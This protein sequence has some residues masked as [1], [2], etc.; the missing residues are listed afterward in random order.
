MSKNRF[1]FLH[2][3]LNFSTV[4]ETRDA[5]PSDRYAAFR[6]FW[7]IFNSNLS[8]PLTP[9]E[10]LSIDETLY[11]MRHQI[12]F[13]QF[14][15]K[16]LHKYGMLFKSLNDACFPYTYKAVPYAGKPTAGTGPYY[17]ESTIDYVK[18]LVKETE[19]D[20]Y[21]KGNFLFLFFLIICFL[22]DVISN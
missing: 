22:A 12:A 4:D 10:Y 5:W 15:P 1:R 17:L 14:N 21:L 6:R 8:K 18:Y 7:E 16:K 20:L 2:A 19:K 9:S 13:R 11:P 3:N